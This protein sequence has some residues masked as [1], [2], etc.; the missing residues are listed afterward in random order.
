MSIYKELSYDQ[1]IETVKGVQFSVLSPDEIL[2]SSVVEVS[3][4]DTYTG[5]EPVPLGL[6]D[7][8]MGVLEHNAY[9]RTCEQKST[10]CPGHFGHIV[11]ARPIFHPLFFENIRKILKC[12]CYRCSRLIISPTASDEYREPIRKIMLIKNLQKRW[13]LMFKLCNNATKIKCCGD[14][15]APGCGAKQ[16]SRYIKEGTLKIIAHWRAST[17]LEIEDTRKEF[18]AQDVLTIFQR[19]SESEMEVL[20]FNPKWNRPEWLIAT[21]IP[22]PPP[23]VAAHPPATRQHG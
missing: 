15:N 10:F 1:D 19:I 4:T 18:T 2:R 20:G 23:P 12:V 3:K 8:R 17:D 22:V 9:C 16:P 11:L 5:N 7:P 14:D 13:E 6:F 21:V